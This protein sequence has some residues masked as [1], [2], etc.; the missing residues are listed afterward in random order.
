MASR[1][2]TVS[3]HVSIDCYLDEFSDDDIIAEAQERELGD[4]IIAE[5]TPSGYSDEQ[6]VQELELRGYKCTLHGA[7]I[8]D[9]VYGLFY[10][11]VGGKVD[12][13]R[14]KKFFLATIDERVL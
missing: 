4:K 9:K 1:S 7:D 8:E 14:I 11:F 6:L 5:S 2:V 3:E 10:D 13:E 12:P